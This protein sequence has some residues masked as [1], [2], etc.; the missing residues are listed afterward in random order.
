MSLFEQIAE[1]SNPK[2]MDRN[3]SITPNYPKGTT[4]EQ[5]DRY[6][7]DVEAHKKFLERYRFFLDRIVNH[8]EFIRPNHLW[9]PAEILTTIEGEIRMSESMDAPNKPGYTRANND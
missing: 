2:N 6:Y 7:E 3:L 8:L 5:W 1:I 9:T 4:K